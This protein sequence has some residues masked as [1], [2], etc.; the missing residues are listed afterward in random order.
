MYPGVITSETWD[1]MT[2]Y[3]IDKYFKHDSYWLVAGAPYFS[4]YDISKLLAIFGSVEE[5]AKG[6]EDFRAKTKAA[7]FTDLHLNAV[8]WGQ[9]ILPGE[10]KVDDPAGLVKGLGFNSFTSYVWIHHV[11]MNSFPVCSYDSVKTVY[12]DYVKKAAADFSIPYYPNVSM[13][14]DASPRT[15]QNGEFQNTGYPYTPIITGNSPENFK[16]A[17]IDSKMFMD[18]QPGE[19]KILTINSWNEWTEGSYLEPDTVH[20]M[21]YLIAIKEVFGNNNN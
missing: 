9:T 8:V 2:D 18:N 14:W 11:Q 1:K 21:Q 7:G 5:T 6:L 15:N 4:V 20:K 12:F 3:I 10:K 17:L 19:N 13:G 16:R